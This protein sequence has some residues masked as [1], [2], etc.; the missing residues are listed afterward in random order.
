MAPP[1]IDWLNE[2]L[3]LAPLPL[4][5]LANYGV[6]EARAR[7]AAVLVAGGIAGTAALVGLGEL[8]LAALVPHGPGTTSAPGAAALF[9]CGAIALALVWEPVREALARI[10]P[11]D[12]GNPVHLLALVLTLTLFGLQAETAFSGALS[13]EA[14]SAQ[15][16]GR[17]DL[18]LGEVPFVLAA[19]V[20]VGIVIRR[21]AGEVVERL[22]YRR[23]QWWHVVLAIAAAG[24]FFALAIGFDA[25]GSFLTPGTAQEVNSANNR[26]FGQLTAD[27]AGV[28]TIAIAAGVCEEALFRG[29]LQPRLGILWTSLVFA[30]VHSQY[31]ISFD[32]LAVFVLAIGLGLL[33]RYLSTTV[34]TICHV[35]YDFLAGFGLAGAGLLIA[36]ALEGLLTTLLVVAL[37]AHLRSRGAA[38]AAA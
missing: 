16:L 25:L 17:L 9:V 38:T 24:G 2:I 34:S 19:V 15:P 29:A 4:A 10:I 3:L 35:T 30:S 13:Q 31:G 11:I 21:N 28:A 14:G 6:R 22:G 1:A 5:V 12:P 8:V 33:R 36:G 27:P 32:A 23:P 20:G 37:L 18:V 26:I 7:V